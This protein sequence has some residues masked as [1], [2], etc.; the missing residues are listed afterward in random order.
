MLFTFSWLKEHL[1]TEASLEEITD[2]LSMLGLEV[3]GIDDRGEAL[4]PFTIGYVKEARQHP[5]ADRLQL[6]VVDTGSGDEQVVC[7]APN[8]RA[9]MKGVFAPSGSYIPGSDMTL[10]PSKIRGEDSNGMLCSEREM[11]LSDDHEGIIEL[12]EDAPIGEGWAKWAGMDDAIIDIALTPNRGDCASVRGIARDLAAAGLGTLKPLDDTKVAGG[13]ES[14]IKWQRDFSSDAGDAC[15]MVVGRTFR[16]V[17]NGE[18]PQ[19]LQ[20]RLRAIGLRPISALVDITNWSTFDLGRPLHVFDADKVSGDLTMRFAKSGE[21][22]EALDE[23]EYALEDG[24]IVIADDNGPQ[25]IGGVMGGIASGCSET[26]KNVFLEVALFDPIRIAET[27]RKLGIISD[28]RYRFERGIDPT[29]LEWGT[30]IASR[31]ILDIC[32]GEASELTVAG[33]LP[34]WQQSQSLRTSRVLSLGG[35]DVPVAEQEKFLTVLGFEPVVEGDELRCVVPP[36]RPDIE[37]EADLVEEVLRIHGYD[38][39]PALPLPNDA[40][41]PNPVRNAAQDRVETI[42]RTLAS[43]GLVEAVTY[44]FLDAKTVSLFGDVPESLRLVN[45]ISADLDTMRPSVLPNLIA[46]IARNQARGMENPSL[47]EVGPQ[48]ADDTPE[49]QAMVAAGAR[50]GQTGA[51]SWAV[52]AEPVD[53]FHAKAD[54]IAALSAVGAPVDNLQVSI[55]AP[56]WYHPGRSGCLRLGPNILAQFGELHPRVA[57]AMDIDGPISVF[58]VF[59]DNIPPRKSKGGASKPLL[60]LSAFQPVRRDFAFIVDED[61]AASDVL[62]AIRTVDRALITDAEL[63]DVYRGKGVEGGKKSLAL[64]VTLQPVDATMTEKEIDDVAEKIVANVAKQAGGTLR[65]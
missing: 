43:N 64:A 27:G 34:N 33:E 45:P 61:V 2:R 52:K 39:I 56:G 15:P 3:E 38:D 7:G 8:A 35:I 26:T 65:G 5:N 51:R 53:A 14:N 4:A 31:M 6:C 12:P 48:Y 47:F 55:D 50:A 25:G 19:W 41:V 11:G 49:G 58:E 40:V 24:M 30:E 18:S 21:K 16:N 57:A 42:R 37:G 22:L 32:G 59:I 62:R 9:G 63:F 23:R 17:T 10:K 13:F 28:A 46:A 60:T 54:V 29:S 20:D 44:S 36:W 1:E